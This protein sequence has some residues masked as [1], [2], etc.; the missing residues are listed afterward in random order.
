MALT[1]PLLINESGN[2]A[3]YYAREYRVQLEFYLDYFNN[4]NKTIIAAVS[5][6][7]Q[8]NYKADFFGYLSAKNIPTKMHYL[9]MRMNGMVSPLDFGPGVSTIKVPNE[10]EFIKIYGF[11]M[12]KNATKA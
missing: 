3:Y 7:D 2:N 12:T 10:T 11:I 6:R 5:N 9:T 1:G 4:S 8:Y